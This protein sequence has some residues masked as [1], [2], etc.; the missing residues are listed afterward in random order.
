MRRAAL[1]LILLVGGALA[2][3]SCGDV[4]RTGRAPAFLVVDLIE[5]QAGGATEFDGVLASDVL[6]CG[7]VIEDVGRVQLR[8]LL[9]D[10]G[11][12]GAPSAPSN[13]NA[14]QI[15]RYRVTYRRADGRNT[16]GVDVPYP[17]D[18]AITATITTAASTIGFTLVRVQA[19][20]EAPL[21]ALS[22]LSG[23]AIVI[24]TIADVTLYGED[25][26]GN[27][28]ATTASIGV[29]FTDW[30]DADCDEGGE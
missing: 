3:A 24:S 9:R 23:G 16:P 12:P 11:N 7:G 27:D 21:I 15:N 20:L 19:K 13:L 10:P 1:P 4:S 14:L 28:F 25:L 30:A 8:V 2:S 26:A 22:G 6:T 18:G 29:D 17:F 5:A